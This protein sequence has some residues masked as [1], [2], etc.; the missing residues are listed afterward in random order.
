MNPQNYPKQENPPSDLSPS[1]ALMVEGRVAELSVWEKALYINKYLRKH[2]SRPSEEAKAFFAKQNQLTAWMR[3]RSGKEKCR[4]SAVGDIMWVRS[5]WENLL[6]EGTAQHLDHDGFVLGNL[7]TPLS[8]RFPHRSWMPDRF[9]YCSPPSYL[10]SFRGRN[11]HSLFSALSFANNHTFDYG[12]EGARDTLLALAEAKIPAIGVRSKKDESSFTTISKEA[13]SI[14]V[15]GAT[16]G[17]NDMSWVNRTRLTVN[18]LPGLAPW[19]RSPVDFHQVSRSMEEMDKGAVQGK[20]VFL[21]WGTEFDYYP[22]AHQVEI[23]LELVKRGADLVLGSHPHVPQPPYCV[24]VNGSE[25]TMPDSLLS[26]FQCVQAPGPPRIAWVAPS[27]GNFSTAMLTVPCRLGYV[28]D[29]PFFGSKEEP[30]GPPQIT[31]LWNQS[32]TFF[33]KRKLLLWEEAKAGLSASIVTKAEQAFSSLG[34]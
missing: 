25:K 3:A 16:F 24:F 20:V 19:G 14:G 6:S 17:F 12:D 32:P 13:G 22:R 10:R 15:Y 31:V 18:T 26:P 2:N 11:G 29:F 7:E 9:G 23:S 1:E 30:F 5:N 33:Q 8:E 21:H 27:L 28:F 4:L 34:L